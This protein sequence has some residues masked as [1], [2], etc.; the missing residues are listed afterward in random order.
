MK[1]III[2]ALERPKKSGKFREEGFIPGVLYGEGMEESASVKFDAA[3]MRNLISQHGSNAKIWVDYKGTKK[4]GLL[5]AVQTEVLSN[6]ILNIDVQVI[7]KDQKMKLQVPIYFI[8]EDILKSKE[9]EL[10]VSKHEATVIGD[11]NLMPESIEIDVSTLALGD[12]VTY[13]DLKLNDDLVT[14]DSEYV[15]GVVNHRRVVAAEATE[16]VA[17]TVKPV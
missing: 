15:Y 2:E 8:G 6:K 7:A 17:E 12:Q 4:F 16:A 10:H 14:D 1:K 3:V 9:L 11:M 5:K 13:K